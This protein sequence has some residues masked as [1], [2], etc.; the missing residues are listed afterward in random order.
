MTKLLPTELPASTLRSDRVRMSSMNLLKSACL[1]LVFCAAAAITSPAQTFT[2]LAIFGPTGADAP[3]STAVQGVDGNF[4]GTTSY[5]SPYNAPGSLFEISP[6]GTLNILLNFGGTEQ[7]YSLVE[8]NDGSFYGTAYSVNSSTPGSVVKITP[9]GTVTTLY[10]FCAQA[11]CADGYNPGPLVK[12]ANG[13]SYGTTFAGGANNLG[14]FFEI[15]PGGKLSTLHSFGGTE[16]NGSLQ[17]QANNGDFYGISYNGGAHSLGAVFKIT[18]LGQVTTLYSFCSRG[19]CTDG[20]FPT[21]LVQA[22]NGSLYGTTLEGGNSYYCYNGGCGTIFKITSAGKFSQVH[23]FS[24][25]DG[26]APNTLLQAT[27]GNLYGTTGGGGDFEPGYGTIFELQP[28]SNTLTTL[29]SFDYEDGLGP[30]GLMQA[31]DGNFYGTALWGG[32]Y[33]LGTVF[34]LSLG[35]AP[36]VETLPTSAAVGARVIILGNN[37]TG[38][39]GVTFNGTAARFTVASDTE[40]KAEVPNGAT[41][42][43]VKVGTPTGTLASNVVFRVQQ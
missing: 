17:L 11:N 15:S 20:S 35:L 42:G 24:L 12:A 39:T 40:I 1:M 16:V 19:N 3:T 34:S 28:Q 31:T 36:F 8:G 6:S 38:T 25:G 27:D 43:S 33:N 32:S 21:A 29:H 30:Q 9:P 7:P 18:A 22:G 4:Y 23:M 26:Q 41:T 5:S 10:S 13:N 37:L 14:T 2:S